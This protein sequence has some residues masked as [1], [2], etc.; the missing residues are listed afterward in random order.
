MRPVSIQIFDQRKEISVPAVLRTMTIEDI[1]QW[2]TSWKPLLDVSKEQD[3][4]WDWEDKYRLMSSRNFER[5]AIEQSGRT[6]GLMI[7]ET[8]SYSSRKDQQPIVYVESLAVAPWNRKP[9]RE[10]R[11]VGSQ[12]MLCAVQLSRDVG[13]KW[14]VG[15]HSLPKAEGFY[16]KHKMIDFGRSLRTLRYFEFDEKRGRR[17]ARE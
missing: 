7:C 6:E 10:F 13:F 2:E 15:L 12:M 11:M 1:A 9:E 5:F 14:R 8:A 17:F 4:T 3:S 16:L